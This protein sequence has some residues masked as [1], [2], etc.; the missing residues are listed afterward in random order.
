M[1]V[2]PAFW[3]E[4]TLRFLS[5]VVVAA[6]LCQAPLAYAERELHG[7]SI[8]VPADF[9]LVEDCPGGVDEQAGA[10]LALVT[11][12]AAQRGHI[13]LDLRFQLFD[14]DQLYAQTVSLPSGQAILL[15]CGTFANLIDSRGVLAGVL[16]H[17]VGHVVLRHNQR[18]RDFERRRPRD[19]SGRLF[20][21][22]Q[23]RRGL[24]LEAEGF[25][26]GFSDWLRREQNPLGQGIRDYIDLIYDL[27]RTAP[28]RD[29]APRPSY[30]MVADVGWEA[31]TVR[32]RALFWERQ[33]SP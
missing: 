21:A 6:C 4:Q 28:V 7:G 16:A 3:W 13:D 11:Q 33:A 26:A 1:A 22:R 9:G 19:E 10:V 24:E 18:V 29:T 25:V 8:A 32:D 30:L 12:Y 20:D 14:S 5:G 2:E 17:E 15:S 23:F 31:A 27:Q